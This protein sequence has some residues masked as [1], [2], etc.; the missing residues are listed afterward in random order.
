[1]TSEPDYGPAQFSADYNVS[2][3]TIERLELYVYELIR[4]QDKINL[5][6]PET[7]EQ[8]WRRHILDSAQL[9]DFIPGDARRILDMGSGAG[10][11][12]M[13]LAILMNNVPDL[14][15]SLV[16]SHVRKS[17]FLRHIS[18][19]TGVKARILNQRLEL[20]KL[21]PVDVITS[22]ALAP[23]ADLLTY[24][25]PFTS[26]HTRCLF[27]KGQNVGSELTN[28]SK[29][30]TITA[31]QHPSRSESTGTVLVIKEFDR[32]SDQNDG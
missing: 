5:V 30:W 7:L 22:R 12:G 18:A 29:C 14:E 16:E 32:V 24:A 8:V 13:V 25:A 1:M 31:S 9:L 28:A 23:V 21:D 10:F 20:L 2:R 11:P 4:W 15:I 6:G 17:A 26:G 27:L 3:E 19:V